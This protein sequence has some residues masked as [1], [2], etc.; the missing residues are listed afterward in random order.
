MKE[1]GNALNDSGS[2]NPVKKHF[3]SN[4]LY[5]FHEGR[6]KTREFV[7]PRREPREVVTGRQAGG[8]SFG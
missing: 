4:K 1:V 3:L 2:I 6:P 5:I 7:G 8:G